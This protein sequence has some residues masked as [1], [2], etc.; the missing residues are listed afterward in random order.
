MANCL[1]AL[2]KNEIWVWLC[3][4]GRIVT[5][6]R[7]YANNDPGNVLWEFAFETLY[8]DTQF[9]DFHPSPDE[10]LYISADDP[11]APLQAGVV[12]YEKRNPK[13]C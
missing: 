3:V 7:L 11:V 10:P 13:T 6:I 12:G 9:A 8:L 1:Y 4:G 5:T 2:T